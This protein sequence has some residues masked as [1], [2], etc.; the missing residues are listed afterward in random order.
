VRLRRRALALAMRSLPRAVR[1]APR[2]RTYH[3]NDRIW[4]LP[5]SLDRISEPILRAGAL[6][7]GILGRDRVQSVVDAWRV[8]AAAP[9]Q[10]IG[11]LFVF[12]TY[13]AGLR[14]HLS[15]A[16]RAAAE[17]PV[18]AGMEERR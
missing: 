5:A 7:H 15:E 9:S 18:L 10:V 17:A 13:H 3:D 2:P 4:R 12:E 1:P 14:A 8:A 6:A 16:R 11:A